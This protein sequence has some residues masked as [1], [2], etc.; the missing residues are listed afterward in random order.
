M[1]HAV[2]LS[3]V[4]WPSRLKTTQMREELLLVRVI[5]RSCQCLRLLSIRF[6]AFQRSW[7]YIR[8]LR[9]S[10]SHDFQQY[11]NL[12][13]RHRAYTV[14]MLA[15]YESKTRECW[16]AMTINRELYKII[17][18]QHLECIIGCKSPL[19]LS[20]HWH[21][22]ILNKLEEAKSQIKQM[23]GNSSCMIINWSLETRLKEN[24]CWRKKA[25]EG[26]NR[27]LAML[28][29]KTLYRLQC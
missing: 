28:Y 20:H 3:L 26:W 6:E 7:N 18:T 1:N 25:Q 12:H 17:R 24:H 29:C 2:P 10:L 21:L 27:R 15:P 4:L 22:M 16:E 19:S 11:N 23:N 5:P 9:V 13:T 8:R 14:C